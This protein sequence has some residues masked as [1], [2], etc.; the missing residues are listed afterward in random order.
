MAL[1]EREPE[2]LAPRPVVMA[3]DPCEAA[4]SSADPFWP[5]YYDPKVGRFINEDPIRWAGGIN[6]YAYV[7]NNPASKADHYGLESG[8]E[9]K[10]QWDASG[11]KFVGPLD[12]V[13]DL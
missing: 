8:A 13:R 12:P 2:P 11:A 4:S 1:A 7:E 6:R 5:G 10:A 9:F 3:D